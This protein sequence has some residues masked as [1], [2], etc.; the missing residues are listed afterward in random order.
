M[1]TKRNKRTRQRRDAD[2]PAWARRL[3]ETGE[4]PERDDTDP[5]WM[6]FI[7]WYYLGEDVPGLPTPREFERDHAINWRD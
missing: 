2:T 3:K 1:P 5:D 6:E 7:T 4:L